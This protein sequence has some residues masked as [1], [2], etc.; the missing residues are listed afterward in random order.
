MCKSGEKCFFIAPLTNIELGGGGIKRGKVMKS[1]SFEHGERARCYRVVEGFLVIT[2]YSI[3][4]PLYICLSR[5]IVS[6][7]FDSNPVE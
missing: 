1:S 6:P 5:N 7:V 2:L 3:F 4:P